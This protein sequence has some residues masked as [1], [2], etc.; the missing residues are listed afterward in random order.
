MSKLNAYM[1]YR[2]GNKL[3][4]VIFKA[5]ALYEKPPDT[6][7]SGFFSAVDWVKCLNM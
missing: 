3:Q 4:F 5:S 6:V 2:D 1:L 7:V